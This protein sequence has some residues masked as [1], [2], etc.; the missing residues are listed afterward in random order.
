MKAMR[1]NTLVVPISRQWDVYFMEDTK[2]NRVQARKALRAEGAKYFKYF[3]AYC[4][5]TDALRLRVT[6]FA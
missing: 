4:I 5:N 6:G 2:R 1:A 3:T